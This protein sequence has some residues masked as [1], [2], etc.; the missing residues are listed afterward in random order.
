M[1]RLAAEGTLR[2]DMTTEPLRIC[3]VRRRATEGETGLALRSRIVTTETAKLEVG[4]TET[5]KLDITTET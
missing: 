1:C 5:T 3:K 4:P 2:I